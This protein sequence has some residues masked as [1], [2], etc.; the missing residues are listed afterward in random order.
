LPTE[1]R[2]LD[3][4]EV[5]AADEAFICGTL[6]EV[7][8]NVSQGGVAIGAGKVGAITPARQHKYMGVSD[9]RSN[10]H[11]EWRTAVYTAK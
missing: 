5:Y 6:A 1:Q 3:R 2:D 8:P 11:P 10:K 7:S 9:G 4:S